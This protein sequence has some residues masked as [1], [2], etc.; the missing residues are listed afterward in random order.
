MR[1]C[2][3]AKT[4]KALICSLL[5][6]SGMQISAVS[7]DAAEPY[8]NDYVQKFPN[9]ITLE[10]I[11]DDNGG[12]NILILDFF[13]KIKDDMV[14]E[15]DV[16][17]ANLAEEQSAALIFGITGEAIGDHDSI[18]AGFHNKI[19]D[20]GEP[21]RMWGNALSNLVSC[22]DHKGP[23]ESYLKNRGIDMNDTIHMRVEVVG[24]Q[25]TLS[26][27]N[28][29]KA[30]EIVSTGTWNDSNVGGK[31]GLMTYKSKATF[32]NITVNGKAYE[33][34]SKNADGNGFTIYGGAGDAHTVN[35]SA[36]WME[37]FTYEADVDMKDGQSAALTFGLTNPD[38]PAANWYGANFNGLEAR[39]FH[40]NS[41]GA[42]DLASKVSD[43]SLALN[44]T[45]HMKLDVE[46]DGTAKYY[47]YNKNADETAKNTPTLTARL[48]GY[49]G[50]YVGALTFKSS[51]NFHNVTITKKDAVGLTDFVSVNGNDNKVIIDETAKT[52]EVPKVSG[53]HFAMYNGLDA[54]ANDFT[55]KAHVKLE[56]GDSGSAAL[57][58]GAERKN[59]MPIRWNG[60]NFDTNNQN[61]FRLFGSCFPH[62]DVGIDKSDA[63]VNFKE[64]IYLKLDVQKDGTFTYTFGNVGKEAKVI[65]GQLENWSG[66]YIGILTC[67]SNAVFSNI[68]FIDRTEK[69]VADQTINDDGRFETNLKG[70]HYGKG[71]W[72]VTDEGLYSDATNLG[73]AFLY[74]DT[75]VKGTNFVY[76]TDVTFKDR[77]GAAAL[78][79]RSNQD[80]T[81][82]EAYAVNIDAETGEYKFWRW[83]NDED[84]QLRSTGNKVAL[85][86][87]NKYHLDVVAYDGW[88]SY[89]IDGVLVANL[90]DYTMQ[91]DNVGQS[92]V[93]KEGNFG[94]LNFNSK[95]VFQNT[96]WKPIEGDFTPLL[97]NIK[98][99]PSN[100]GTVET[101]GQFV[102]TESVYMQYV[103]ND[104]DKID[105]S[106][107]K[108]SAKATV[109]A[110]TEDKTEYEDLKNIPL[111]SGKNVITVTSEVTGE[112]DDKTNLKARL[113][114]RLVV[115]RRVAAEEDYYDEQY[116]GQYHYSVKEG[117]A[118]DP[119]GLVKFNGKY[120]MFYQFFSDT[121]WGPMHWAH[122]T[123]EDLLTW[124]DQ[125]TALYPDANGAMF[126][127]CIVADEKNTSGLFDGV[128]GGGLVA[129]ITAD[130]NGQR[131]KVAYSTDEGTT[132][133]KL[134][135]IVADF[136][137]DPLNSSDFRD[138]KV[139]RWENKWFMVVAGGP[140]RIYSSDDLLDWK[141]ESVYGNLHTECPDLYP[142]IAD[143]NQLKWVLSR[144]GR[145]YKV[146][147][148]KQVNGL[149]KFVPDAQYA[150]D[151]NENDGIMNFG[152]DSYA[153]MTYY[154]QDFGTAANPNIPEIVEFN[155]MNTWDNY[156]NLVAEQTGNNVFNGTFNLNL[157]LGLHFENGKYKLTQTPYSG[158]KALRET[159]SAKVWENK[160]IGANQSV[161]LDGIDTTS[162]EIVAN[163]KPQAGTTA[164]GFKVRKNGS[165]ETIIKYDLGTKNLS[166]DR[167]K[168]GKLLIG[169]DK[170]NND[171][172]FFSPINQME[173]ERRVDG[174]VDL[175]I[176]VDRASVEVFMNDYTVAGAN[177]IFPSPD[178]KGIE[179]FSN[180][181]ETI[182][183]ITIYPLSSIWKNQKI[184]TVVE[185][186][187][188]QVNGY[189]NEA[190]TLNAAVYPETENQ[191]VTW[192]VDHPELLKIT[193]AGA[194]SANFMPLKEGKVT[195]TATS[196]SDPSA[197][198]E[199]QV[200]IRRNDFKTNLEGFASSINGWV[201]EGD[202]Y[203]GTT[204][205]VN[206][207]TFA[208]EK[209]KGN[210]YTYSADVKVNSGL[211]NMI[212]ESRSNPYE[213]AY[214]IQLN[215][216]EKSSVRLFDFKNDWE[217]KKENSGMPAGSSSSD[218]HVDIVKD[219]KRV[220]VYIDG[221]VALDHTINDADRQYNTGVFG[222]GM[223]EGNAEVRNV[224]VRNGYPAKSILSKVDDVT[225]SDLATAEDALK[226]LPE[227]V[228]VADLNDDEI[229]P[230]SIT[231][232]LSTV[233][234]GKVGTYTVTGTTE[235]GL[236]TSAKIIIVVDKKPLE[237][238]IKKAESLAQGDYD[239]DSWTELMEA[240]KEAKDVLADPNV[241]GKTVLEA[242]AKLNEVMDNMIRLNHVIV[243]QNGHGEVRG[244]LK[245]SAVL[246]IDDI[247]KQVNS[248][249]QAE[250]LKYYNVHCLYEATMYVN[251]EVYEPSG[252][253]ELRL[254]LPKE[255]AQHSYI[256][257]RVVNGHLLILTDS[258][259]EDGQ[260]VANVDR[261]GTYAIVSVKENNGNGNNDNKT[262]NLTDAKAKG[263]NTGDTT[264]P[265]VSMSWLMLSG[266][267]LYIA[268]KKRQT[269]E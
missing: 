103:S 245:A 206:A 234:F 65:S 11:G 70:M 95:V 171:V 165:E 89:Y 236:Q 30:P 269:E 110:F 129:L 238:A 224:Y 199:C 46:R 39:L 158:Y 84:Y 81:N 255:R 208:N 201:I 225:I 159:A 194:T 147:D 257:A 90:G 179:V 35:E 91:V 181:G 23:D 184:T 202:A 86:A 249:L 19:G 67:N 42:S 229:D 149:W 63:N 155:W 211:F 17:L 204:G 188:T 233:T 112:T 15:A 100:A 144:G 166:I 209:A 168:S 261:L 156:C 196:K 223:W 34:V 105:L 72:E 55:F 24:T 50:G 68:D 243:D 228:R 22:D 31:V 173:T 142:I 239:P 241:D 32:S 85:K 185:L 263:V 123:S 83:Q 160:V 20:W 163:L 43:N 7:V 222:L 115:I 1:K 250:A 266:F 3:F 44:Q 61:I 124:E 180:G 136:T 21:A 26:L 190:F 2:F 248:T 232:D 101:P 125:P 58:F 253:M 192:T 128:A 218:C 252:M 220:I 117:W 231:W 37:A 29:G 259:I 143:N 251:D 141:C 177:Q 10:N 132:W 54:K 16:K 151:G 237:S 134:D 45:V 131:I 126:S 71:N 113:T 187:Q 162:Y 59:G 6:I 213:G 230:Q 197:K 87:D 244:N 127:G 157:T 104:T 138:P 267:V 94:L 99:S 8:Q 140:L 150:G 212:F 75:T 41:A 62:G 200:V 121:K 221:Q 133:T 88:I 145:F 195:I 175:H 254:N 186:D 80:D 189:V 97:Q 191:E 203:K 154:V 77:K 106:V 207:F 210:V 76:S 262:D 246:I 14:F 174:S 53:D 139:F 47:V 268:M 167:S 119:N 116:R 260:I 114:Y 216:A 227:M 258:R 205:A 78:V 135:N 5:C 193:K 98:V 214:A 79:F 256:L 108:A 92:T 242:T 96:Y 74:T 122:A 25:V 130:G 219:G 107:S 12:N 182:A 52:V 13:D 170:D 51:A 264:Q 73:D 111:K 60:A 265:I 82:K 247:M 178:S 57:V 56:D 33:A 38:N 49:S 183:D 36:G 152:K 198:A 240:L 215:G 146:G 93:L 9:E 109:S 18:K 28:P 118:N 69:V 148:F 4:W 235:S 40:V 176:F 66:G 64:T 226:L 48:D 217:F 120:H 27:N 164:V 172:D 137:N 161:S 153:A 102:N 169:K